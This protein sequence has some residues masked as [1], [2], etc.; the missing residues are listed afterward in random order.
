MKWLN[1]LHGESPRLVVLEP[2]YNFG[3]INSNK[4]VEHDFILRNAGTSILK[5]ENI[6]TI[7]GCTTAEMVK[8]EITPNEEVPIHVMFDTKGRQGPQIQSVTIAS[9]DPANPTLE[10]RIVG[11]AIASIHIEPMAVQF[12][13]IE[14]ENPRKATVVIQS[15]KENV[16]FKIKSVE[17]DGLDF[18]DYEIKEINEGKKY[19]F[20]IKTNENIPA[21][22]YV[23]KYII[24]TNSIERAV[25]WLPVS[26][27]LMRISYGA[28][29][30]NPTTEQ[31]AYSVAEAYAS[32]EEAIIGQTKVFFNKLVNKDLDGAMVVISD[33]FEHSEYG[34][35]AKV[36]AFLEEAKQAGYLDDLRLIMDDAEVKF[37]GDK[38]V[39][40]PVD[41]EGPSG[42]FTLELTCTKEGDTWKL[43][44]MDIFGI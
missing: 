6:Q 36:K 22:N 37:E 26:L 35:K 28:P 21:G 20:I 40:Y 33:K 10:L 11:E 1:I 9:N 34:S 15:I 27:Q 12:G 18:L 43:T 2:E 31:K 14:D 13:R 41:M 4:L 29:S 24:R 38:V 42:S 23:G 32:P 3:K 17:S 19:E 8:D 7:C 25:I 16:K 5:I 30:I 44:T 39:V